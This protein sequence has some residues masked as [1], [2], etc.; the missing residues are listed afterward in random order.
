VENGIVF[1]RCPD[2]GLVASTDAHKTKLMPNGHALLHCVRCVA[3]LDPDEELTPE[4]IAMLKANSPTGV[5]SVPVANGHVQAPTSPA[6]APA[7]SPPPSP[8][9]IPPKPVAPVQGAATSAQV[10][11]HPVGAGICGKLIA[12]GQTGHLHR[13][14]PRAVTQV[15]QPLSTGEPFTLAWGEEVFRT[16]E[17]STFRVGPF[18]RTSTVRAGETEDMAKQRVYEDLRSFAMREFDRKA[19]DHLDNIDR[20][21]NKMTDR[22]TRRRA[23]VA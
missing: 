15:P 2:C 21:A 7:P 13:E 9:P 12:P 14:E 5:R 4:R 3:L 22:T 11:Q 19:E 23:A 8:P 10:C 18:T 1:I 20:L 16:G 6:S 17:F